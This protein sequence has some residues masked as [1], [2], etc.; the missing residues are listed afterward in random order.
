LKTLANW[1]QPKVGGNRVSIPF[2][3]GGWDFENLLA[4]VANDLGLLGALFPVG[5][6]VLQVRANIDLAHQTAL[7]EYG[8]GAIDGRS[9]NCAVDQPCLD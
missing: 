8:K 6:V 3:E 9:G 4:V 5:H 1:S 2:H 7:D